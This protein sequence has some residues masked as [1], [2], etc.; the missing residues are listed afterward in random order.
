MIMLLFRITLC[1][2]FHPCIWRHYLV[3]LTCQYNMPEGKDHSFC[4][5]HCFIAL[6]VQKWQMAIYCHYCISSISKKEMKWKA[7]SRRNSDCVDLLTLHFK[8]LFF[9]KPSFN[10]C[11]TYREYSYLGET[12]YVAIFW[13][14][15]SLAAF[16]A[17]L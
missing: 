2:S 8:G 5:L 6:L 14:L 10:S 17:S 12:V 4:A 15:P 9:L 7:L 11:Y 13:W 16:C 3:A 1:Y